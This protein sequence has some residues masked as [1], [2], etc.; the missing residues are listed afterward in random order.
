MYRMIFDSGELTIFTPSGEPGF[1]ASYTLFRDQIEAQE[2]EDYKI[3]ARW[4]LEDDTLTFRDIRVPGGDATL[5]T[6]TWASHPW[7]RTD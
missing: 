7:A 5:E 2:A 4:S 1:E 6:V 3:I